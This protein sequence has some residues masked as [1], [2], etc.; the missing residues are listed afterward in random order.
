MIAPRAI[1]ENA[2][3]IAGHFLKLKRI[4]GMLLNLL[5]LNHSLVNYA[6][7]VL[8]LG[9]AMFLSIFVAMAS[10]ALKTPHVH[11]P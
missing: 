7:S 6:F 5:A 4:Y 8:I 9:L 11:K 1:Q 10:V 3:Y 2:P